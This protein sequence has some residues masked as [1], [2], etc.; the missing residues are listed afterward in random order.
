MQIQLFDHFMHADLGMFNT[1]ASGRLVSRFTNDIQLMRNA[2]SSVLTGLAKELLTL[3]ALIG[4]M[5]YMSWEL[6]LIAFL[7]FPTAILPVVR[8]GKRMRKI[9]SG[10]Q[11]ELGDFTAQL[12]E[13]FQGVRVVKA[14]GREGY[15]VNRARATIERLF[16]LYIKQSRIQAAA[17]PIME[18]LGGIGIAAVIAYGGS[19]VFAGETTPGAFFSFIAAM[20]MAYKPV[21]AIAGLNTQ[22]QEGLAAT[23]RLYTV[24]DTPPT[25]QDRPDAQPLEVNEGA[26][27]INNLS[28]YYEPEVKALDDI[29]LK[30]PPGKMAALV[31]PSGS[32]KSTIMN[33]LL[34]FY[35]YE[36]GRITIDSQEIRD[37]TLESLRHHIGLVS[38]DVMLFDDSAAANIAYGREGATREEIVEAARAADADRFIRELPE[39]YDTR[40]GPHGV[41]LSGG[42]RQR[43]SIARAM[44]KNAPIL[45]LDE[46][47]SALDTQSERS[48]QKAL[49]ELM[50]HR[51]T[52]VI[53]HRLSTVQHA[54][55]IYV[56]EKGRIV[57]SGT[58]EQLKNRRGLY[59]TLHSM[60]FSPTAA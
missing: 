39:G 30:V 46:A 8:L 31:G 18:V 33:L 19:Q 5:F 17:S 32:G 47:T 9:V 4:V 49:D 24:L 55:I 56:L 54:D 13:T 22:L 2:A 28:F 45:L 23:Q 35:E 12:D 36:H 37:V 57:E 58:H 25:V 1:Q 29:S 14:Y 51:T 42:Q 34:R 38:Q 20:L 11:K 21:R 10:T 3:V 48:V 40:I 7:L 27:E 26:L 44:L 41:K 53:A 50:Q 60:Q 43:L 15:E 6:S 59:A 16:R 52:L